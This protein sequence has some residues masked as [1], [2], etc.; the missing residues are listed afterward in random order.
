MKAVTMEASWIFR[1]ST[2]TVTEEITI[3]NWL[4]LSNIFHSQI[5]LENADQS[6]QLELLIDLKIRFFKF[7]ETILK[8]PKSKNKKDDSGQFQI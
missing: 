4:I 7:R 6:N 8:V 3:G 2:I 1:D 5:S